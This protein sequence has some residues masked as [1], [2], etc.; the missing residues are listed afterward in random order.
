[1]NLNQ[2]DEVLQN[3]EEPRHSLFQLKYFCVGK[4]PT[5]QSRL[6]RCL[7]ELKARKRS[8]DDF[9]VAIEDVQDDIE[10][11]DIKRE[12]LNGKKAQ[13]PLDIREKKIEIQKIT[14][15]IAS[16]KTSVQDLEQK[17]QAAKIEADFFLETYQNLEKMEPLKPFD[18]LD[19]NIEMW[20]AK[21]TEE[22]NLRLLLGKQFDVELAKTVLAMDDST[23]VKQGFSEILEKTRQ[24]AVEQKRM[25]LSKLDTVEG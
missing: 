4:E 24:K 1:M 14:R 19:S 2:I 10:L 16:L 20:N 11:L 21:L 13:E 3:H 5:H 17:K 18:D 7:R 23:P 6:H 25:Q 12:R 15:K 22:I 8:L 9:I